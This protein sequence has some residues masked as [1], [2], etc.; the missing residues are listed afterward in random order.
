MKRF[1][2]QNFIILVLM[3]SGNIFNYL[4]QL[5]AGRSMTPDEYGSFNALNSSTVILSAPLGVVPLIMAR[6]TA[7]FAL[8]G[9]G[10]V[11]GLFG[12]AVKVSLVAACLALA[13]GFAFGHLLRDFLHLTDML[14]VYIL[15]CMVALSLVAPVPWGM[16]QGLQ[17][18]TGYGLSGASN[19][20][21]R[22]V[23]SLVFLVWL[24][25][26]VSGAMFC[27]LVG[28]F[29]Q[30]GLAFLF[31]KDLYPV[32]PEPLPDG[33]HR[34]VGRYAL[35]MVVSSVVTM[36]L[37][38]LDLVLV[39]HFCPGEE[40]GLYATAAILGRIAFYGPSVLLS[41]LFTEAVTSKASGE[42][43]R[44]S[45]WMS[46]GLTVLLGGGFALVCG[47]AS[48]TV[49]GVLFGAQYTQAGP[50]LAVISAAMALL[51]AANVLFVYSQARGDFEFMWVQGTGVALFALLAWLNHATAMDVARMLLYSVSFILV[52]TTAW[53]LLTSRRKDHPQGGHA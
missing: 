32:A 42:S 43:G 19:A 26:G 51:A 44:K 38:N 8:E 9:M 29:F 28:M 40:A 20:C 24:G 39:R 53:F 37:N 4:F 46:L 41:V 47:V 10:R 34:E 21:M 5:T 33:F 16:L 35:A 22:F 15:T 27:G 31:L 1:L 50:L 12:K 3:N 25:Q 13:A 17:R 18:F 48:E 23:V 6:F 36:C 52:A 14:P 11:R 2:K 45:L 30:A 7:G 49:V